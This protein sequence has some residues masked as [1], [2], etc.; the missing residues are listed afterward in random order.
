MNLVKFD[1]RYRSS[2]MFTRPK[3]DIRPWKISQI[4]SAFLTNTSSIKWS[5][6]QDAQNTFTKILE[7]FELKKAGHQYDQN[8]GG[9]RTYRALLK[10]LGLIFELDNGEIRATL[11]GDAL[12]EQN[13]NPIEIL[14]K[15]ILEYQYPS[16]Y[17][18]TQNVWINPDIQIKPFLFVLA[19]L[20]DDEIEYLTNDELVIPVVYGHNWD[21]FDLCKTK[22]L[23]YRKMNDWNIVIDNPKVDLYT[24]K[25]RNRSFSDS[26]EDFKN[27]ANTC[28]NYLA[29]VSLVIEESSPA[30]SKVKAIYANKSLTATINEHLYKRSSF[31]K[32][33]NDQQFQ[34]K[35][36][37]WGATK[38]I[39]H[40]AADVKPVS[41]GSHLILAY[42]HEYAGK[43][44]ITDIPQEFVN[45][46]TD[47]GF[48]KSVVMQTIEPHLTQ[49]LAYFEHKF[50]ELSTGGT[51]TAN[52]F[53]QAVAKLF[54]ERL[55]FLVRHTGQKKLEGKTGG[56]SDL[57]LEA[58]DKSYCAIID[59][60]A[61]KS[62]GLPSGDF[63]AMRD[64][65][66]DIGDFGSYDSS[67]IKFF[68]YVAG[69]FTNSIDNRLKTLSKESGV[70]IS[71]IRA[72]ELLKLCQENFTKD[73]VNKLADVFSKQGLCEK[74]DF[75]PIFKR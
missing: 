56:Y 18:R 33:T 23:L 9:A 70:N 6:N 49:S 71:A 25:S 3:R 31:I 34:R 4:L 66:N 35:Y 73:D 65:V 46:M 50:L 32:W 26:I 69:N 10:S 17:S 64:Y 62:Y 41:N 39:R 14:R 59:A 24:R 1:E 2:W 28:K 21:C 38:D 44:I 29:A 8:S 74:E 72:F 51:K 48:E 54:S 37:L 30:N 52:E 42:F 67:N 27:I 45:K 15:Q 47:R 60:K 13:S 58:P 16:V 63:R 20:F 75:S 68:A 7:D 12:L 55:H 5:G 19:L 40:I 22:I 53:E 36:G 11:A 57:F 43:N 61:M